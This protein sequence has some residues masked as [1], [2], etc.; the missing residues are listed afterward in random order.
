MNYV[1]KKRNIKKQ[2]TSYIVSKCVR[3]QSPLSFIS[4][5]SL[6]VL[7]REHAVQDDQSQ[8]KLRQLKSYLQVG[9]EG[10]KLLRE[11]WGGGV[12]GI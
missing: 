6:R 11:V 10:N 8:F 4:T 7:G 12:K 1:H 2:L 5:Y 9:E 3:S